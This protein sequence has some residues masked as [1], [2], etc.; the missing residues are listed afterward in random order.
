MK[1]EQEIQEPGRKIDLTK[2]RVL[3]AKAEEVGAPKEVPMLKKLAEDIERTE[4]FHKSYSEYRKYKEK[5]ASGSLK[6]LGANPEKFTKDYL[7]NLLT[8]SMNLQ[9]DLSDNAYFDADEIS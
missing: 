9:L 3:K 5:K 8:E 2:A 4:N 1:I 7:K 6:N